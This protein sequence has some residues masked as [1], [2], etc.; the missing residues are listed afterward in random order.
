MAD[1]VRS[2]SSRSG[3]ASCWPRIAEIS[4]QG[5][6]SAEKI[7]FCTRAGVSGLLAYDERG[8]SSFPSEKAFFPSREWGGMTATGT[9]AVLLCVT[10]TTVVCGVND[11]FNY[12][13]G[14]GG[15]ITI[16]S[17]LWEETARK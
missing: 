4:L 17:P 7:L 3:Q 13:G 15:D 12:G 1:R 8:G 5:L 16:F 6:K 10:Q 9:V 11:P 2:L 14:G